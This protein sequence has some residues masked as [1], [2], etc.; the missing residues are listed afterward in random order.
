MR[1]LRA[2]T[3]HLDDSSLGCHT[4][5]RDFVSRYLP[6]YGAYLP[7]LY[8]AARTTGVGGK[9]TLMAKVDAKRRPV[10]NWD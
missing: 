10:H 3:S 2:L 4:Q 7:G 6:A 8:G 9:P 1:L 5:V